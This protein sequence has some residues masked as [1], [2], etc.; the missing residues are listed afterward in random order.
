MTGSSEF[1]LMAARRVAAGGGGSLIEMLAGA[2]A[3]RAHRQFRPRPA[4]G[5]AQGRG[6]HPGAALSVGGV[7]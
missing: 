5:N 3:R 2:A 4:R 7:S 1:D 6:C